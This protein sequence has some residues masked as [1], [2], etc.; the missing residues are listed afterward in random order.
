[1]NFGYSILKPPSTFLWYVCMDHFYHI[2]FAHSNDD[3]DI[4]AYL[5]QI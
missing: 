5:G 3:D 2:V 4:R 1:M